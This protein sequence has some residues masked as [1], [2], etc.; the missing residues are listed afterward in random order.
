MAKY[1]I[2]ESGEPAKCTASVRNCPRGGSDEHFDSKDKA[3][4][5]IAEKYGEDSLNSSKKVK[6]LD[7]QIKEAEVLYGGRF[8]TPHDLELDAGVETALADLREIGN[9]LIV[10]GAVR[11]SFDGHDNKDIDIEVHGTD[12]DTIV[13]LLKNKG[14]SVDE[15]GKKFGV[16]K[17]S[18]S[19]VVSDLD[20]A[21]P[22]REN[23]TGAGHRNFEV[24]LDDTMT[25]SEAAERR[26]FT[27]NAVMVDPARKI[28]I[29]PAGGRDDFDNKVMRHVSEKF[30]EDPLRVLRGFQFAGRFGMTYA[31]ET[32]Q[33][34]R[35]LRNEYSDLSVERV[36]EEWGKYFTKSTH[37]EMGIAALRESGWD[38][39]TPGL[40]DALTTATNDLNN[41][42][43]IPQKDREI[44][45]AALIARNMKAK[46]VPGLFN[47]A[48]GSNDDRRKAKLFIATDFD[49]LATSSY[50]RKMWAADAVSKKTN[51][52]EFESYAIATNDPAALK[53]ARLA[54]AEGVFEKPE[55]LLLNG[56]EVMS[57]TDKKPGRW[58]GEVIE[59]VKEK[60]YRGELRT[61][62]DAVRFAK[63]LI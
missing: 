38:D 49:D 17:A 60:Q 16:L 35:S 39:M 15:V 61:K 55:P 29:D 48:L 21:V 25:V 33:L 9:P 24:E 13:K 7:S 43:K 62:D 14:Y 37:P 6:T 11:D 41:L 19:G 22:R 46:D 32:A 31:P 5:A 18:K 40:S 2:S 63:S 51:F 57:Y 28:L 53:A 47:I 45:G 30:S 27:F 42:P 50:N 56:N 4:S 1:H 23:R 52:K 58:L 20:V 36:R 54:K 34:A 26:D 8:I 3:Y 12:I 44:V 59:A 10:G